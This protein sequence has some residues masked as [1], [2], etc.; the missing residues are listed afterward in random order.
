[1]SHESI[2]AY[3]DNLT[4][5]ITNVPPLNIFNYD[6]TNMS[7]DPGKNKGIYK[8][9]VKYPEKIMNFSKSA[10]TIMVCGS[11]D[12]VLLPPYVIYKSVHLYDTWKE[13]DPQG[14]PCCQKTCCSQG[15]RFNRTNSGWIDSITF[16]D[17]FRTSFLPHAKALPGRKVLIG[18]NLSSRL[19]VDVLNECEQNNIDFVCLVPNPTHLC[20]PLDVA[21]FRPMK[22]AWKKV[23]TNWKMQ[24]TRLSTVPKDTFPRLLQKA[25]E[26][27]DS[28]Q[29]KPNAPF[30]NVSQGVKRNL[31]TA[32]KAT[33]IYPI[34]RE[35]VLK[36]L[37]TVEN[38]DPTNEAESCLTIYL[39]GQR[40]DSPSV[41]PRK[42]TRLN[43][44]PGTSIPTA[45]HVAE[46]RE[47]DIPASNTQR[48]TDNVET[49][50]SQEI[51]S[52]NEG[53]ESEHPVSEPDE[54]L[55][56][57][58]FILAKFYSGR[59]KKTYRYV[60]RITSLEPL[61]VVG[62]KSIGNKTDF[63]L[64]RDDISEIEETDILSY[65]SRPRA[66]KDKDNCECVK[67]NF[68]V[69]ILELP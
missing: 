5:V 55:E 24:N 37:P 52:V 63:K 10:T 13:G 57:G 7:D 26:N 66:Y 35:E 42:R 58:R 48:N 39:K 54:E 62:F 2:N 64:V 9:G 25:L 21:F 49:A 17:W 27:I 19:D 60:C 38:D 53:S 8:R 51:A 69:N 45:V 23:L 29:A 36:R 14:A 40:Y 1:M 15:S 46:E 16:R 34:S 31:I 30:A 47:T 20:Q 61:I 28:V 67:F 65:L 3:F 33:G 41:V 59:G 11:A 56:V 43:A 22:G 4:P 44:E 6:E 32:F 12:G 18:D 50:S 68:D